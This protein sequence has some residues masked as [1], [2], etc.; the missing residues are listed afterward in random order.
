M[1]DW[2]L[3]FRVSNN[4]NF[5]LLE[6][7]ALP[8]L[9]VDSE[10]AKLLIQA[11]TQLTCI[12]PEFAVLWQ[13]IMDDEWEEANCMK[14]VRERAKLRAVTDTLVA[15]L[16]GISEH[17]FAYI[18]STFPL[19]D[20]D[21]PALPGEMSSFITR[22]LALLILFQRR[23]IASPQDIVAFFA[24]TGVDIR[25]RTGPIIDLAETSAFCS[26]ELG[27]VAYLPSR[28]ERDDIIMVMM[29]SKRNLISMKM[30][31][32]S[33]SRMMYFNKTNFLSPP[34]ISEEHSIS[35]QQCI[36][37]AFHHR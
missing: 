4:V 32:C 1:V 22:D 21:Q 6:A 28:R 27:A 26:E 29:M 19:L 23:G 5:F 11:A 2:L 12:T 15:D 24:E 14:D 10:E 3:R 20:R 34:V 7:L 33:F 37:N 25:Q 17:D 18:L 13:E 36:R 35:W 30:R 9:K 8:S 16:Y 31:I